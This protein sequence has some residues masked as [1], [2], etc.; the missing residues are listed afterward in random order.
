MIE[1]GGRR[2]LFVDE[3]LIDKRDGLELRL[4]QP[5]PREIVIKHDAPWEG[6]GSCFYT[7]FHDGD[8]M[9]LYYMGLDLTNEDGTTFQ[10]LTRQIYAC[11]AESRD[12]IHWVKPELGIYEFQGSKKNNIV[13]AVPKLDNFTP[14]KDTNPNCP[15]DERYKALSAGFGPGLFACKSAD[16]IHW[17]KLVE[18]PVAT[19]G[20]FDSQTA[21]SGIRCS[22]H[23]WG[24]LRTSTMTFATSAWRRQPTAAP[25]RSPS[26]SIRRLARR[27]ALH[28]S[29]SA[30]LSCSQ[31]VPRV[32]DAIRRPQVVRVVRRS[33]RPGAPQG[34][35]EVLSSVRND[36]DRR[37][38][39]VEPGWPD[40]PPLG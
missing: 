2:E 13:W 31:P 3:F 38:V 7:V 15:P 36:G 11:Y 25:G 35:D 26:A 14:F 20:T 16:G 1:L 37:V 33:A 32:P 24:Y 8:I 4:E 39:H 17:S 9:R 29:D 27:A 6:S 22:K 23:Y 10:Y 19:Q 28:Q 12:G 18:G 21:P 40:V 5:V 30:V 34:A